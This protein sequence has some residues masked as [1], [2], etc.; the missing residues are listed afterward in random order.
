MLHCKKTCLKKQYFFSLRAKLFFWQIVLS[1]KRHA[2]EKRILPYDNF[3]AIFKVDN[4]WLRIHTQRKSEEK[5]IIEGFVTTNFFSGFPIFLAFL[6][7]L[8]RWLAFPFFYHQ[9]PW[10]GWKKTRIS[11]CQNISITVPWMQGSDRY[12]TQALSSSQYCRKYHIFPSS[13]KC[14]RVTVL[15]SNFCLK[16]IFSLWPPTIWSERKTTT[17]S[18]FFLTAI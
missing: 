16:R 4:T 8:W 13:A 15:K 1:K 11:V 12:I 3:F 6:P 2:S 7:N 17:H 14:C 10:I 5:K 9:N 18:L